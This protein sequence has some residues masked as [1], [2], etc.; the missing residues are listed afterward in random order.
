MEQQLKVYIEIP[1]NARPATKELFAEL[2]MIFP[3]SQELREET[4]RE[5]DSC[6][7]KI[8]EDTGPQFLIFT[9]K[10]GSTVFKIIEY[11]SRASIGITAEIK[12]ESPQLVLTNFKTELGLRIADLFMTV[13]PVNIESN[14]VVNFAVHKDFIFF[15]MYRFCVTEKGPV[16]E[17]LGPHLTLRLWRMT[18][19]NDD[20]RNVFNYQKYVK[21]A[22]LL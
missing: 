1:K 13:F 17:K 4:Q 8:Q 18:E 22:N 9:Y 12:K 5:D 7:V 15:R 20:E 21:N 11:R 3:N 6:T 19:Y 10:T 16:F 14:Q 2:V